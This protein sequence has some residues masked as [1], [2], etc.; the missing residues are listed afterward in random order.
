M[1]PSCLAVAVGVIRGSDGKILIARRPDNVHQG[2][3]WEFPGG[4]VEAG[5]TVEQA[6]RR[7][8]KE[9]LGIDVQMA[10]PLIKIPYHYP[11]R[12]VLL[13]VWTVNKFSG[14]ATGMEGQKT[15]WVSVA[16][17]RRYVFPAANK[18]IISALTLPRFYAILEGETEI[19]VK[20]NLK[21]ILTRDISLVQFRLK[22]LKSPVSELFLQALLQQTNAKNCQVLFNSHLLRFSSLTTGLHLTSRDLAAGFSCPKGITWLGASCHNEAELML[23]E[24]AGVDFAVI[25]P[26]KKTATH[27][28]AGALGWRRFSQLVDAASFP[29]YALGGV[30]DGDVETAMR[31]G[32]QGIAGIRTFL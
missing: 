15:A 21:K 14:H 3:L 20:E 8:L 27:P 11:E 10:R 4:K 25:A 9:E 2:G 17:L 31:S 26:V 6:L 1:R 12:S 24:R 30:R 22:T 19:Q 23:A 5:E 29:V 13:D 28:E 32:A 16:D 18:A 7:E